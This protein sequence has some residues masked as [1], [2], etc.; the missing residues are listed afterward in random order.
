[1]FW[2]RSIM[3]FCIAIMQYQT[4][5]YRKHETIVNYFM[6]AGRVFELKNS[7]TLFYAIE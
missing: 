2:G 4:L 3:A 6:I 7:D 1:M 5:H